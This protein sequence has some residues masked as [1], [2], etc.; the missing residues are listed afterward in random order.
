MS[1]PILNE[2]Q[3]TKWLSRSKMLTTLCVVSLMANLIVAGAIGSHFIRG[4]GF[5]GPMQQN[6]VQLIPRKFFDGL[7][8]TRRHELMQFIHDNREDFKKL[9]QQ[10][11]TTANALAAALENPNYDAAVVK[12][13]IDEFATGRESLAAKAGDVVITIVEK[14]TPAERVRLAGDIRDRAVHDDEKN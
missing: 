9:R 10:S 5:G 8:N 6:F 12:S 4:K 13:V 1:E 14:L 3:N 2:V 11:A 7:P